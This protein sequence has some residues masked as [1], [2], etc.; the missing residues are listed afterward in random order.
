[1]KQRGA[2]NFFLKATTNDPKERISAKEA[3]IHPWI[4]GKAMEEPMDD[5]IHQFQCMQN[6][7]KTIIWTMILKRICNQCK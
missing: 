7:F 5:I 3:L 4:L 2:R 6:I 1:M